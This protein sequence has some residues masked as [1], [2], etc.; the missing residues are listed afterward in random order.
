MPVDPGDHEGSTNI[1]RP[2]YYFCYNP[3]VKSFNITSAGNGVDTLTLPRLSKSFS[4]VGARLVLLPAAQ[5]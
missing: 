3:V 2:S 5:P 1:V 4:V